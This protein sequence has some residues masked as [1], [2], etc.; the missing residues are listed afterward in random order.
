VAEVLAGLT[1]GEWVIVEGLTIVRPGGR[2]TIK[3]H[4]EAKDQG[5]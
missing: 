3:S 5:N 1:P 2:V 4:P